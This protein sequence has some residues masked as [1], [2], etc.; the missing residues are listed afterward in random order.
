MSQSKLINIILVI[1]M[2]WLALGGTGA[3]GQALAQTP[4]P[5]FSSEGEELIGS[6]QVPLIPD[7]V[8]D[9][10]T[11]SW[12]GASPHGTNS[13]Q[14]ISSTINF[15]ALWDQPLSSVNQNAYVDQEFSDS[16]TYSS[17]LSD[18]FIAENEWEI[19]SIFVPG[20]GWNGFSSLMNAT[21]LR[22][23]IYANNAG[24]PAGDPSGGGAAPIW[25]LSLPPTDPHVSITVG[26][27]GLPSNTRVTFPTPLI[28]PPGHYWLLFYPVLDF[29]N[30]GQFGLQSSDTTNGNVAK[31]I[32][33]GGAFGLGTTWIDW[34]AIGP[35]QQD[36][37]FTIYGTEAASWKRIAPINGLGRSR[38]AAAAVDGKI[39]LF[40]GEI[41]GGGRADAVDEYDPGTNTWTV[42]AG[43]MPY[44]AS[45][46]CAIVLGT[47][48]YI[49]G[50]Y[51]ASANYLNTLQVY[52]TV[53]DYWETITTDPLP[54]GFAGA[55]CA[56]LNGKLYV[57]GGTNLDGYRST[58]YV[59]DPAAAA[60]SRWTTLPSMANARAYLAGVA[61]NGK[62]YAI[63]GRDSSIANFNVVEAYN[64]A[65]G[66]WHT[67]THMQEA[68][69]GVGAY[70]VG[71]AIYACGG[72]WSTYLD[73]CEVYDTTQGYSGSWVNH[74]A[75]LI[76]G[77]RTFAYANIGPV[78]YAIAG[79]N[80][81]Y[82]TS[83]ERWSY[84][85][86]LP[87]ILNKPF[88]QLGFDSQFNGDSTGWFSY[89]GAYWLFGSGYVYTYGV[90]PNL[91][92][93]IAHITPFTNMDY[94]ARMMRLGCDTCSN[95]LIIRG[96]IAP[97]TGENLWNN[98]YLFQYTRNGSFSV[99]RVFNG[100]AMP[101]QSWTF[102]PAILA[103]DEWN[104]L[105]VIASGNQLYFFINDT[106]LWTGTDTFFT[107]GKVGISMYV[108]NTTGD[109][110]RVDWATLMTNAGGFIVSDT[111]SPE[112]QL[113]ND[114]AN[115]EGDANENINQS[116]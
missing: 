56:A 3:A 19:E 50:G 5:T 75:L 89:A 81:N 83:A 20:S 110:L 4:H 39:Y 29:T 73:T 37:A 52:H 67:V 95:N 32:N 112:Q 11:D 94:Q 66:A 105:R 102:S 40:G 21:E 76:E 38:P 27:A 16:P 107:T 93:S 70:A 28:L 30:Y 106:L 55:G 65:D 96:T 26:S 60:G 90:S 113:L 115:T 79:W 47:N 18:D 6:P 22:W 36:F 24:L 99:F 97:Q 98:A 9:A 54:V 80:G 109:E 48:V 8:I 92:S 104:T 116:P 91:W 41:S 108:S 62:I 17:Y 88:T 45:N 74:P 59:Y 53:S 33:P 68:R 42:Q 77:R 25:S 51:D 35:I 72:G 2:L 85:I 86:F 12:I 103:G 46:I 44:P 43:L 78:L 64:P 31:F 71:N 14:Q 101:L 84:E 69:G 87:L 100:N 7:S 114:A 23:R 111:V 61:A 63:G 15:V 82:M 49:P 34:N 13:D 57:F 1:S 58:A 10:N